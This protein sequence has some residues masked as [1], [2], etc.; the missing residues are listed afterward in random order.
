MQQMV[1]DARTASS[2]TVAVGEEDR[3]FYRLPVWK[4]IVIMF[5]GPF[6]NL[7]IGVVLFGVLLMGFGAP[8]SSTTVGDRQPVRAAREAARARRARRMRPRGR[9]PRRG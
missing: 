3:T 8:Q 2:E 9:P 4:R 7:L 6:M 1:Q 5:G